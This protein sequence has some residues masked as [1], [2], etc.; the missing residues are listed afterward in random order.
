MPFKVFW[1]E[2][3]GFVN[4]HLR[5]YT[6][7]GDAHKC[8]TNYGHDAETFAGKFETRYGDQKAEWRENVR[9]RASWKPEEFANDGR[10][11][12]QCQNGTCQYKFADADTWQ[13][14]QHEVYKDPVTGMEYTL[15]S[16]TPG[17]MWDAWWMGPDYSHSDNISLAVILPN[18]NTW[19]VDSRASNC[20]SPCSKCGKAY[21]QHINPQGQ[22]I[23]YC[24]SNK[25]QWQQDPYYQDSRPH[26]C[27]VRHG[28]PKTGTVHVDKNGVTCGAGAGSI[29]SGSYH[30]F[31]HNGFLTDG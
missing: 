12:A 30:G 6:S 15:N 17:M 3:A 13:V 19:M 26:K 9:Y 14:Q 24:D 22:F 16:K 11:P 7:S 29:A 31:L 4:L 5:R 25:T 8:V 27:W 2:P 1:T 21:N 10:W 18:G 20:D 23:G 28:D